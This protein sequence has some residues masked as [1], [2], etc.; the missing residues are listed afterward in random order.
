MELH[1]THQRGAV[2]CLAV[3]PLTAPL[4]CV[5]GH[6][7]CHAAMGCAAENTS[8]AALVFHGRGGF[9]LR[10]AQ[11]PLNPKPGGGRGAQKRQ[12]NQERTTHEAPAPPGGKTAPV[13]IPLLCSAACRTARGA[14]GGQEQ[15]AAGESRGRAAPPHRR[16]PPNPTNL[17]QLHEFCWR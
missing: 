6:E 13:R 10:A 4:W 17:I 9:G 16:D 1:R 2:K 7:G 8:A 14:Q 11:L 15:R 12:G 3:H 5:I